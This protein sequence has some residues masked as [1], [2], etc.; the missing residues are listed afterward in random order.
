MNNYFHK[1]TIPIIDTSEPTENNDEDDHTVHD[2]ND[3][4]LSNPIADI[5][6]SSIDPTRLGDWEKH[7]RVSNI[8]RH[9]IGAH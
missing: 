4:D 9:L 5:A 7:T 6:S 2:D 3:D 1:V 8:N